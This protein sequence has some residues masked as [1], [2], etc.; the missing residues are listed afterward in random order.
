[1]KTVYTV[2]YILKAPYAI[3]IVITFDFR[4]GENVMIKN[5]SLKDGQE[6]INS[7]IKKRKPLWIHNSENIVNS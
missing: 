5:L 2:V 1:M 7:F 3:D 4:L 6:G